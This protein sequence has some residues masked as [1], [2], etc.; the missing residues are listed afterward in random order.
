M[1]CFELLSNK[2][3]I[4]F[5]PVRTK[6]KLI[7]LDHFK[8]DCTKLMRQRLKRVS[9]EKVN[10]RNVKRVKLKTLKNLFIIC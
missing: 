5:K 6:Q 10:S 1:F 7:P 9:L 4:M 8:I 3:E 2:Y